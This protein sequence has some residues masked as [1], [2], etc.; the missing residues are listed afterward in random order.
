MKKTLLFFAILIFLASFMFSISSAQTGHANSVSYQPRASYQSVYGPDNRLSTY[1]PILGSKEECV[2]RED[3][4]IQVSP[5]GC[6]P[7]VVRS[8]LLAEQN[9]PVFCQLDALQI[10]PLIDI[11]SIKSIGFTRTGG[12]PKEVVGTGYHPARAAL[13]TRDKLLGSPLI[14]NIGYVVV[15]LKKNPVE[16]ELPEFV[17]LTLNAQI[18]YEA[19]NAFGVGRAEFLL[20]PM[21]D[22]EWD[23]EKFKNSFWNGRYYV[24]VESADPKF[25]FVSL[26]SGDRGSLGRGGKIASFRVEKGKTSESIWMPGTYCRAG[27]KIAYDGYSSAEN[28][29]ILRISDDKGTDILDVHEGTRFL[30]DKCSVDKILV[31]DNKSISTGY[32]SIRCS[33]NQKLN[34][35]LSLKSDASDKPFNVDKEFEDAISALKKVYDEYPLEAER[36][37]EGSKKWGELALI[38]AIELSEKA[39]KERTRV[40][41]LKEFV[42][43]YPDSEFIDN[44]RTEFNRASYI[45]YSEAGGVVN[46]DGR[47]YNIRVLDFDKPKEKSV[48]EFSVITGGFSETIGAELKEKSNLSDRGV[49]SVESI[50]VERIENEEN[51]RASVSCR[52]SSKDKG[53][54]LKTSS[55]TFRLN[56]DSIQVCEKASIRLRNIELKEAVRIRLLPEARGTKTET[57]FSV[58]IGI[59]KRAIKLTPE[60]TEDMIG[61]LNESIKRWESI[62]Q[63]LGN[64]VSGLKGACFAT[65]AVLTV[66]NFLTGIGGE[67]LARQKVMV[68]W[69][70]QCSDLVNAGKYPTINACYLE[71]SNEI[72]NDVQSAENAIDQINSKIEG[73]EKNYI[74][75][76]YVDRS[77]AAVAYCNDLKDRYGSRDINVRGQAM[78]LSDLLGNCDEGYNKQGLYGYNELREIEYNMIMQEKGT[79]GT[80]VDAEKMLKSGYDQILENKERFSSVQKAQEAKS[81]GFP[82]PIVTTSTTRKNVVGEVVSVNGIQEPNL[83]ELIPSTETHLAVINI[84]NTEKKNKDGS[85]SGFR[86]NDSYYLGLTKNSEGYYDVQDV[87][88]KSGN[89]YETLDDSKRAEFLDIYGVVRVTP[90]ESTSYI[91]PYKNPEARFYETEPYKG[92]PAIVPFDTRDGWYAATRQTLPSFGGI[93]AFDASGRVTSFYLCNVGPNGVEQFYEGYGD[94]ICQLI[95]LNTGQPLGVFPGLSESEARRKVS[96]AVQAITDASNQYGRKVIRVNGKDYAVGRPAANIPSSQCQNFMSPEECHLM[97]NVCDPVICPSSRCDFGGQYPVADVVQTGIIG[98][99]LLCLPNVREKIAVPVC[100]TGIHAGID[101]FVSILKNHRDCLQE[102]LNTGSSVGICDQ[103]YSI[104]LCEFFWRQVAPVAKVILPKIVELAYGQGTRG[105]GEYLSVGAAWQNMQNSITYFTQSYAVNSINAFKARNIEEAGTPFCKAFVSAKAPTAFE[106]LVEP[107]SP[108]QFHAWFSATRFSDVT[109]PATSQYKIFYHIFAGKDQGAQYQVYLRNPPESGFFTLPSVVHVASGFVGRGQYASES[110]DRTAPE[111]YKELCVRV[112][113]KEECG[114]KEVSTSFAVNYL[115]DKYVQGEATQ[116]IKSE[117]ECISGSSSLAPLTLSPN[118][119]ANAEEALLPKVYDRGLVR[120]CASQNPGSQ[121]DPSRFADVGYCDDQKLRCWLDKKSVENAIT[122]NNAGLRNATLSEI[123]QRQRSDLIQK[124][125]IVGDDA[126]NAEIKDLKENIDKLRGGSV[127]DQ[128]VQGIVARLETLLKRVILNHHKANIMY[129]IGDVKAVFV[130]KAIISAKAGESK[131]AG[132]S[133]GE[134]VASETS[135]ITSGTSE[136]YLDKEY[137]DDD[138]NY[139]RVRKDGAERII[140]EIESGRIYTLNPKILIATPRARGNGSYTIQFVQAGN[141]FDNFKKYLSDRGYGAGEESIIFIYNLKD[142]TISGSKIKADI[143]IKEF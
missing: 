137:K 71:K 86:S 106:S 28:K 93:G 58:N 65:A 117:S 15:V 22:D 84:Y 5:A 3:L 88:R 1:W 119:Q 59:E 48:A 134:G 81:L 32:V 62:N 19:G 142:A 67:A 14:N 94:D 114:F 8:D 55:H 98:S 122:D 18:D 96:Q 82:S 42:E 60:R 52:I 76:D 104:Y 139:I 120:I 29:A 64:L 68:G 87:F 123:E 43:R 102:S 74:D 125:V 61:N 130:E 92:M 128:E 44:Y 40:E 49:G 33:G 20:Q 124:G 31:G 56:A 126:A 118:I 129:L 25:A 12:Y 85:I 78:K 24:R 127:S 109:V 26:Y 66:K 70:R 105:G 108:P 135:S 57:N 21:S 121:T 133:Q 50:L 53:Y 72:D 75:G 101:G 45:D 30:N 34:L 9:V 38:R 116:E 37:F 23:K 95:N 112:N 35:N 103:I 97:F 110:L 39:G 113:N 36:N 80:R 17:N 77:K 90:A 107:D 83:R 132:E 46:V 91:N 99:T 111:G 79:Q 16:N 69:T 10:N 63:R 13:R 138:V 27:L 89:A 140:L 143:R 4:I 141:S 115:R 41:L 54:E 2:A 7:S 11:D 47:F 51:V 131:K 100:L 6:T 136:Y 73:I